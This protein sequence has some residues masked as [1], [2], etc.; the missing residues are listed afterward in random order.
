MRLP[1]GKEGMITLRQGPQTHF[2]KG[3][4]G[5]YE[6]MYMTCGMFSKYS[7]VEM[8]SFKTRKGSVSL[9]G[10]YR[11]ELED[12]NNISWMVERPTS[13]ELYAEY[14]TWPT[15]LKTTLYS[16]Y[17]LKKLTSSYF[18]KAHGEQNIMLTG[19]GQDTR[20]MKSGLD[21][22]DCMRA[23][24]ARNPLFVGPL[25]IKAVVPRS[26]MK[27]VSVFETRISNNTYTKNFKGCV[28]KKIESLPR[29]KFSEEVEVS[30]L[31]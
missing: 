11:F 8:R 30:V 9:V 18:K 2:F 6:F 5:H 22:S 24:R 31:F 4:P 15:D 1:D 13:E 19:H 27:Q 10:F 3:D 25:E 21:M 14:V 12:V 20:T 23:E 28:S 17:S 16:P 7:L 29:P 26:R